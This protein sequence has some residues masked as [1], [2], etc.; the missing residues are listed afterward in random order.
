MEWVTDEKD[1]WQRALPS[2]K[3]PLVY[4]VWN[5]IVGIK[6]VEV[7][8]KILR[9]ENAASV[10]RKFTQTFRERCKSKV[11]LFI[12]KILKYMGV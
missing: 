2:I 4:R 10:E 9:S 12:V 6:V 8:L 3:L 1:K 11:S 7:A 5:G